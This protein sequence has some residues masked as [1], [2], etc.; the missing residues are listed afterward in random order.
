MQPLVIDIFGLNVDLSFWVEVSTWSTWEIIRIIFA[1]GGWVV[2]VLIFFFMGAKLWR[3]T[4]IN[5]NMAKWK[6]VVLAIDI[7]EEIIQGPKAVEQIFATLTGSALYPNFGEIYW[8]GKYQKW[9]SLEIVSIEGYIQFLIRTEI[10]YRDLVEAAVY[11]QYPEAEITEVED[12]MDKIPARYPDKDYEIFGFEFRLEEDDVY[13]IRTYSEF[14]HSI[15]KDLTFNDPLAAILENFSRVGPGE[16]FWMQIVVE[17]STDPKWKER[18]IKAAKKIVQDQGEKKKPESFV[19]KIGYIPQWLMQELLNAFEGNWEQSES[20]VKEKIKP[21]SMM[22]L[23]PG[24]R[25]TLEAVENKISKNGFHTKIRALYSAKK[26]I[27]RP[28]KCINGFIGGMKQFFDSNRN[29]LRPANFTKANYAFK[30]MRAS[31]LKNS[32]MYAFRKRKPYRGLS[33]FV[34]NSEELATIWHFPLI[35]VKTPLLQKSALK[36]AEAPVDLPVEV[37]IPGLAIG[38]EIELP[39]V[40]S[41]E[42]KTDAG[43]SVGEIKTDSGD[44]GSEDEVKYG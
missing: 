37:G 26:E 38:E 12:Y 14:E 27:Y 36:R 24:L 7:P 29:G 22:D 41:E 3:Y 25:S 33:P 11:A 2:L 16:N 21:P 13:P 10:E 17:P 6:W 8:K 31:W 28:S 44:F 30:K 40:D 20:A 43:V 15:S 34:L 32:F 39:D 9:F 5:R 19:S 35:F 1:V 4:R 18:G 23:S 42:I